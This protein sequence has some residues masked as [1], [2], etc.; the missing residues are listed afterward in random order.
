MSSNDQSN[1]KASRKRKS[2]RSFEFY[3][4]LLI[5]LSRTNPLVCEDL[6]K[7]EELFGDRVKKA[8]ELV[9]DNRVKKYRFTPSGVIRWVVEGTENNYLQIAASFCSCRD[10]LFSSLLRREVPSCYHLL[11]REIA[12]RTERFEEITLN[13]SDYSQFMKDFL[14]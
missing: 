11:A 7:L 10:F 5:K 3:P 8:L 12:E 9:A 13:D 2:P 1:E 4:D 14:P 6:T